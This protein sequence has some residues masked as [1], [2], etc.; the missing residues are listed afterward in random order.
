MPLRVGPP[1][2]Y[3]IAS[4]PAGA[5]FGPRAMRDYEFVWIIDGDCRYR[6]GEL[7]VEAPAGAMV[8]CRPGAVDAF[9]WDAR[10]RSMHGYVHFDVHAIPGHWPRREDWPLVCVLPEGDTMRP[11]LGHLLRWAEQGDAE[12][13][14]LTLRHLLSSYVLNEIETR[15][16]PRPELPEPVRV[17]LDRIMQVL[18]DDPATPLGLDDLAEAAHVTASHL[19]RLFKAS[20]GHS[21]AETVRLARL[22]YAAAMLARSNE[23][24]AA[25]AEAAGFASPFHFSRRFG[26]AYGMSPTDYRARAR[27]GAHNPLPLRHTHF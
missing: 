27:D 19:C 3:G 4:N 25:V 18:R 17:A 10:R 23:S 26:E 8:L 5:T 16:P 1:K 15:Q 2:H 13:T 21:P 24:V 11:L 20:T 9:D 22:D 14:A 12:L 6:W 7:E